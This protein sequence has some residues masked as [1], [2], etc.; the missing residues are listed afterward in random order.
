MSYIAK[1]L[2][3]RQKLQKLQYSKRIK[4]AYVLRKGKTNKTIPKGTKKPQEV[5]VLKKS[6]HLSLGQK[7]G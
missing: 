1:K 6:I 2:Q 7:I 5:Y 3:N 4:I